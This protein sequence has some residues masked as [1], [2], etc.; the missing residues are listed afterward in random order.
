MRRDLIPH[1]MPLAAAALMAAAC[2]PASKPAP[3]ATPANNRPPAAMPA[4]QNAPGQP[5]GG[6]PTGGQPPAGVPNLGALAGALAGAQGEPTPRPYASVITA[7]ARSKQGVFD[8]HQIGARLYFEIPASQLGKDFMV[9]TVLAGT[10]AAITGST[11]GPTRLVRF[12]RRDNRILLRDVN[13]NNVA[14][15]TTLQTERAMSLIQFYPIIAAFNVDAY[16]KDS[17]AVIDV[18]RLFVGGVQEFTANGRRAVVDASRSFV[19]KFSAFSRNVNV[20]AIQTFTPQATPGA[21]SLPIFGGGAPTSTTEAYTFSIVRLPD[22]PMMPRLADERVGF[23]SRTRTDFG[24]REQRVLPRRYI[25]R[26][27]LEC[28]DRK[29]GNLCVPKKPITYYVDPATPTWLVPWVKAGI[30]EWQ[31]A[32]ETAGFAKG[33]VA[34]EAPNDPDFSGEDA[35]VAMIRWLP[36]PVANAQ[37]PSLVD[38]RTGEIIDADV[39]MYHNILDLQRDWYFSQVGHL[40]KRAQTFPFPDSLMGRLIQFVVAHEVGH[41]LG[42]PHNFKSSSMYPLDSIRSKTWVAKMGHSPSIMDY[43]RF[44]YVAQPE[45]NIPLSDLV[46]KVGVYDKYAVMWGYSPIPGATSPE[47]ELRQLDAWARMQDTIPWYRFANDA[48]AGGADPGEQSE[49][50]GDADAVGATTLGFKNLARVMKLVD[51]AT[52]GDKTAD[53]SLLRATYNGVISQWALEANHVTK[54]VGGLDRQEKRQSQSGPVW[55]PVSRTRQKAAVKFLV[56]QVF[57]TPTYLIDVPTLRRLESEGNINR[58]VNA[59]S[60]TLNSLLANAKLQRLVEIEATSTNQANVYPLGEMLSDV[61]RGLWSELASGKPV[62]AY[63]RRLQNNYLEMMAA[64]IKPPAP[65]PVEAQIAQ[66]LGMP[67]VQPR[68]FRAMVKDEMRTLDRELTAAI[69][70]TGDRASRAHMQDARDQIKTMLDTDK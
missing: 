28:S 63:R 60:R 32:F 30:E 9:T 41:T 48:G 6:Q 22:D 27:R 2:K 39:Q 45:D 69:G 57:T 37:G 40:D 42:F 17:A 59:Q 23:F 70:R 64:K 16:G 3:A 52:S 34:G 5:G 68:D 50:V 56:D 53:F 33:I 51:G 26:W 54:I 55:T 36:S 7:R 10:N 49:A 47:S 29:Q 1:V 8:V 19:D 21:A 58:V 66:L 61:R 35:S 31:P 15:D 38:P 25:S 20:T 11:N 65:S 4:G 18:T 44:N 43:A 24:S 62:T 12:E 13:Y 46:P 14:S 67:L